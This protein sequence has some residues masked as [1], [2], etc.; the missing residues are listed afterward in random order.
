MANS[1]LHEDTNATVIMSQLKQLIYSDLARQYRL[2]G[3][4]DVRPNFF[5]FLVRLPHQRFL[6]AVLYRTSRAAMLAGVPVLPQLLTY[7]NLVLFGLEITPRCEI[8]PGVFFAH[9]SGCVIGA[10]RMGS[11]VMIFQ[12]VNVG[13][14][15]LDMGFDSAVRPEVGDNVVLGIGC[16]V[17]GPIRIGDNAVIGANSVVIRSVEPNTTV[18]GIPARKIEI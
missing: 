6:P 3:R 15:E 12:G 17:L 7:L 5:R 14:K 18:A 8:G 16:V 9:P 10:R 1:S 11:N 13:A 4:H 2:E